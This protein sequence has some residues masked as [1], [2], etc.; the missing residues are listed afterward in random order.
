MGD[1]VVMVCMV[2][3]VLF[4]PFLLQ[5]IGLFSPNWVNTSDCS[6]IGLVYSC[7]SGDNN[8]TCKNT[9]GID[10]LDARALGLEVTSFVVMFLA[11]FGTCFDAIIKDE[12]D[13]VGCCGAVGWCC[14]VMLPVAE[15]V[16]HVVSQPRVSQIGGERLASQ[17]SR[18]VKKRKRPTNVSALANAQ[19]E[20][21]SHPRV[22]PIG[23][24]K[25]LA[26]QPNR[27]VKKRR[28]PTKVSTL[29]KAQFEQRSDIHDSQQKGF[30]SD[31]TW[32]DYNVDT[33]SNNM[34]SHED[35]RRF[36]PHGEVDNRVQQRPFGGMVPTVTD[37]HVSPYGEV[38]GRA[39]AQGTLNDSK[40][41]A[42]SGA[43]VPYKKG[44]RVA[45][46]D[47]V[48]GM[49][50]VQQRAFYD[51]EQNIA[52]DEIV[53]YQ[54]IGD[55]ATYGEVGNMNRAQRRALVHGSQRHASSSGVVSNENNRIVP[56]GGGVVH[57]E[58]QMEQEEVY[59]H[60]SESGHIFFVMKKYTIERF[61]HIF[62][63][64]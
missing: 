2:S 16:I 62:K 58:A 43:L 25:Q 4:P 19:F 21:R 48:R 27:P 45:T 18:R 34:V 61:I 33:S 5:T 39:G 32:N 1:K 40:P 8:D 7:C 50:G 3:C 24:G 57:M 9:N 17:P 54:D 37:G 6:S 55:D 46:H 22:S 15:H 38:G 60:E 35:G 29:A 31:D 63:D 56:S 42:S 11:V 52:S 51:T 64:K 53:S 59:A 13:D 44:G 23:D 14:V 47:Q 26:S 49:R 12:F 28:M 41:Q 36:T 10:E 30:S 20:Q